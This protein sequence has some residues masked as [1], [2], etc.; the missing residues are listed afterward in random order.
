MPVGALVALARWHAK[1]AAWWPTLAASTISLILLLLATRHGTVGVERGIEQMRWSMALIALGIPAAF[2]DPAQALL[3]ATPV[4]RAT[5]LAVLTVVLAGPLTVVWLL[6]VATARARIGADLPYADLGL[7]Y[8]GVV[9]V[10]SALGA[11]LQRR[12]VRSVASIGPGILL[13][14]LLLAMVLPASAL[15]PASP[16]A[17]TWNSAHSR[18]QLVVGAAGVGLLLAGRD[19]SSRLRRAPVRRIAAVRRPDRKQE[20]ACPGGRDDRP[21]IRASQSS[22]NP[23]D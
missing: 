9:M 10:A 22:S 12:R 21:H 19:A 20:E 16:Q 14:L 7:E 18:W 2:D 17:Q 15:F 23:D 1:A 6:L 3:N 11:L 4:R 5:R 13:A 8:A